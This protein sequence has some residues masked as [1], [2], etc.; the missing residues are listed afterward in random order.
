MTKKIRIIEKKTPSQSMTYFEYEGIPKKQAPKSAGRAGMV[1]N[2]TPKN[3][4]YTACSKTTYQTN[5]NWKLIYPARGHLATDL[6]KFIYNF[7]LGSIDNFIKD[8]KIVSKEHDV[9]SELIRRNKV[10]GYAGNPMD[11]MGLSVEEGDRMLK[12]S[13]EYIKSNK[14]KTYIGFLEEEITGTDFERYLLPTDFLMPDGIITEDEGFKDFLK[15]PKEE[16]KP[17]DVKKK[18]EKPTEKKSFKATVE[19]Q[20]PKKDS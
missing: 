17:A 20:E 18:V 19:T 8:A 12:E 2:N 16:D 1:R 9:I 7:G 13:C 3:Y 14:N 6:A 11:L 5:P 10:I 4:H 15:R